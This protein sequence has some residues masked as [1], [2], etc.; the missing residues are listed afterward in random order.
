MDQ[1]SLV[2]Q[3]T[4]DAEEFI[5]L[6]IHEGFDV[7]AAAWVKPSEE[8]RWLLY[9]VSK[10]V[11]ERG[12]SAAYRA[13]H[14]VLKQMYAPWISLSDL[15]LLGVTDPVAVDIA[16]INR[17][18]PGRTPTRTRR[19]QLGDMSIEE[20]YV[21]PTPGQLPPW[22][23]K[24]QKTYPSAEK[25]VVPVPFADLDFP[26]L[27]PFMGRINAAEFLGKPPGTV[28]FVGPE[29]K[30]TR[31]IGKLNFVYRPE[32]WNTVFNPK[33][34]QWEEA[35]LEP[36]GQPPYQLADFSPLTAARVES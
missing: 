30:S 20:A 13:I 35:R 25:F 9:L 1:A 23:E 14:P 10:E 3:Q 28:M 16:G 5:D 29:G 33:T 4:D 7:T 32:G 31:P 12:L 19:P 36:S 18:Y 26:T 15:K 8:D 2:E 6:L 22:F 21:Y 17:K 24:M 34:S 27:G 11:D